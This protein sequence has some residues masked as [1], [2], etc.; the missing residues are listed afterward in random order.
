LPWVIWYS[1]TS[2]WKLGTMTVT[3]LTYY[4]SWHA[5]R[6]G[7]DSGGSMQVSDSGN[8]NEMCMCRTTV[9]VPFVQT[10]W[11][12]CNRSPL[13]YAHLSRQVTVISA[14]GNRTRSGG[15]V[16]SRTS[17]ITIRMTPQWYAHTSQSSNFD[18]C[19]VRASNTVPLDLIGCVDTYLG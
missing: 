18:A 14:H 8:G 10:Q 17:T 15:R 2:I 19:T 5:L 16:S 13:L 6:M 4:G 3:Q 7:T 1:P 11:V 12:G 9:S